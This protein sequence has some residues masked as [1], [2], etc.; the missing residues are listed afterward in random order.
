MA[1][2]PWHDMHKECLAQKQCYTNYYVTIITIMMAVE[3]YFKE[4]L[5]ER[6]TVEPLFVM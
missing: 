5:V 2:Q 3:I 4:T 1:A 6:W